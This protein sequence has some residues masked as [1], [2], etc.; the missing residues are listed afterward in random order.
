MLLHLHQLNSESDYEWDNID[1]K[2]KLLNLDKNSHISYMISD[3]S[4]YNS[5]KEIFANS[6][7]K[8]YLILFLSW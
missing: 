3:V 7:K 4:F 2:L 5:D 8:V 6:K 1:W